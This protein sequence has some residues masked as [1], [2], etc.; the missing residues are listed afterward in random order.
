MSVIRLVLVITSLMLSVACGRDFD[1]GGELRAQR[2][3]LQREVEG[4]R[5]IVGKFDSGQALVADNDVVIG[6]A[7]GLVR[8]LVDAQLPFEA[9]VDRFHLRLTAA[10]VQF[11]GSPVIRLRGELNLR[12]RP[13]VSAKVTV[14]GALVD[15]RI[16][17]ATRMRASV[18][19][20]HL[21]IDEA[22][23]L[24][25]WLSGGTI[26]EVARMVRLQ[27]T[28]QL[29]T[30]QIPIKLQQQFAFAPITDGPVR[31]AGARMALEAAVAD[32]IAANGTLWIT[33]RITPGEFVKVSDA[34]EAG[35]ASV[36]EA[37]LRLDES[38]ADAD[39]DRPTPATKAP[40]PK[41]GSTPP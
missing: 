20:D 14:I 13:A 7:D 26:D 22:M 24:T 37:G 19:A 36:A 17:E 11:R 34:P 12:E 1:G 16:D 39:G 2:V 6:V 18:T 8:E 29:P 35:N 15:I 31:I 27:I 3:L 30:I 32:V 10:D 28:D 40:A 41:K 23:G 9:D 4:L 5:T 33:V 38:A 25:E 21:G